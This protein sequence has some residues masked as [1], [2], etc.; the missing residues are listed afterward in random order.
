M[1]IF[2]V[3]WLRSAVF[4]LGLSLESLFKPA[5]AQDY[6]ITKLKL[7]PDRDE[8]LI[9]DV[10]TDSKGFVWFLTNGEIYRYDGYRSLDILKTIADQVRT[11]DMPQHILI[12]RYDRL[13]M[14]GN[15]HLSYLDLKTW[16][17]HSVASAQLPPIQDRA[18]Y[19][20][21]ELADS[22]IL[23][24]YENGHLLLV[25][26]NQF[27]RVNDLFELGKKSSN[28]LS[29]RGATVWKNK[30]WIGT[31]GGSLLSI[32]PARGYSTQITKLPGED[33]YVRTLIGYTDTLFVDVPGTVNIRLDEGFGR[34]MRPRGFELSADKYFVLAEGSDM[35]VYAEDDVLCVMNPA[36]HLRQ[37]LKIPS[38]RKFRTVAVQITKTEILLGTEEGIFVAYPRT[39]G[40]SELSMTNAGPNTSVR[41]IYGYPDGSLFYGTYSGA[42]Y[43]EAGGKAF[44]FPE[45]KHA[46]TVLPMNENDLLVG[47]EGG[48]LK[49]FNRR[50]RRIEPLKY[51]LSPNARAKYLAHLPI[52]VMCLA[53]TANNFLIGGMNGLWLLNKKS[54]E[55]DRFELASGSPHALDLQIRHIQLLS[56]N[57]LLLSTNLGLFELNYG[58]LSK[59]YPKAGNTGVYKVIVDGNKLWVATQGAGLVTM[60]GN[61]RE[62]QHL[63]T[64][65]GLSNN[66]VYSLERIDGVMVLGTADGLNLVDAQQRVRR[67]GMEEGLSQSEFNSGAS[68]VDKVRKRVYVGGLTGY[69]V[70]DMNQDWFNKNDQL[71]SYVTEI[72]TSTGKAGQRAR[73]YTWPYRG[74]KQ[75]SL[76][77][78]QSLTAL[79]VG[80]PGN[81]RANSRVTYSLN[82][83]DWEPLIR[84]QFIS[85][86]EPSPGEYKLNLRTR[87]FGLE[88]KQDIVKVIK[89]PHF[90]QT[91]WFRGLLGLCAVA[92]VVLWY[93]TRIAKI[94]REQD[95]RNRIAADLHDEVGSSLTRIFFQASSLAGNPVA[96]SPVAGNPVGGRQ[97]GAERQGRQLELIADTSKQALLTMSDMV[98]S[99]DSRFDTMKDLVIRMKDYLY[100]LRE[101]LD[102][103]Y[104]FE[105][106]AEVVS[107]KVSQ[108]V[109]QNLFLIFKEALINAI[110]YSDGAEILISLHTEP[111]IRL[112]VSNSYVRKSATP[113]DRQGGRGLENMELRA[114]KIGGKLSV[115]DEGSIFCIVFEIPPKRG[116]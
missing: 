49:V 3:K 11:T 19:S 72:H 8:V 36:L 31:T 68:F 16:K 55:L 32:D 29:P 15:A 40:L 52:Y 103:T 60:D 37:R 45:L 102:F 24:A 84:G 97:E 116:M 96:G 106:G 1:S 83:G 74:Q 85:L 110:K 18:V 23:I 80:T 58:K 111:F 107:G 65:N 62:I 4:F 6:V 42:G 56:E 54:R 93:R 14:T 63:T 10:A 108:A 94:R 78:N 13:W 88:S 39:K 26:G 75:L 114:G 82:E 71:E 92:I 12:D 28:K 22:T 44:V 101:E 79:Y 47:T 73:D 51:S 67:I 90:S 104:R 33:S 66:L 100:R 25:K 46:Y 2:C 17:V 59:K 105:E 61:G 89:K 87:S 9:K 77:H 81:Y 35:H 86:I 76:D 50:E 53:E 27:F 5:I 21:T 113:G 20:I 69:T 98:W 112:V 7:F 57:H 95:I 38:Q 99:I 115:N 91:W 41:G 48:F 64:E 30:I 70:L 43:M 109:R 34:Q